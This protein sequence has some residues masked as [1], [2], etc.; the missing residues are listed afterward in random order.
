MWIRPEAGKDAKL[1]IAQLVEHLIV[2]IAD[3]RWSLV[4]FRVARLLICW[5]DIAGMR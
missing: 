3:I 5:H 4:R 1:A 2:D